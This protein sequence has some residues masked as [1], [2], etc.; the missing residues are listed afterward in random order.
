METLTLQID[1]MT[2]GHCVKA[3]RE[4]LAELPG[5]EVQDV[6][7]GSAIVTYDPGTTPRIEL[8]EAVRD[9]G[10]EPRD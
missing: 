10:Y 6:A 5:V 4:A 7:I 2:C 8:V 3:V 9:A 1:G